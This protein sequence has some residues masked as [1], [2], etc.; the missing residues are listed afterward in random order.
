LLIKMKK[1]AYYINK[2]G[3]LALFDQPIHYIY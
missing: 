3:L 1:G 2:Q